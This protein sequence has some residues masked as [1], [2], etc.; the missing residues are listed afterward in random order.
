[1][2]ALIFSNTNRIFTK[3][4]HMFGHEAVFNKFQEIQVNQ[5]VYQT[6]V[7]LSYTSITKIFRKSLSVWNLQTKDKSQNGC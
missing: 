5:N 1:M 3:V 7:K 4:F 6:T 2:L